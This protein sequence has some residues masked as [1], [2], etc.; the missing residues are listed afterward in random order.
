[1]IIVHSSY[2]SKCLKKDFLSFIISI[3]VNIRI[4]FKL[5]PIYC[6]KKKDIPRKLSKAVSLCTYKG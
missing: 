2:N 5:Q 3:Q 4:Y 1:M 6:K